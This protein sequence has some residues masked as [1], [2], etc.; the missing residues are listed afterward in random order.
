VRRAG[1]EQIVG[2]AMGIVDF[3]RRRW[4]PPPERLLR[5]SDIRNV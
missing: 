4:G 5:M 3:A 2:R 1:F